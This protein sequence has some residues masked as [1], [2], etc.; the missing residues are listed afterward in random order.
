MKAQG[1]STKYHAGA[2]AA[3]KF[4]DLTRDRLRAEV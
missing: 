4:K 3:Q 1:E 2:K